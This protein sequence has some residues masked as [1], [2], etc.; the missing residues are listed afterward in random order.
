MREVKVCNKYE[1][2]K[3]L[4]LQLNNTINEMLE[5][6]MLWAWKNSLWYKSSSGLEIVFQGHQGSFWYLMFHSMN[7]VAQNPISNVNEETS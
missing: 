3:N 6:T 7:F 1:S 4:Y 2:L 5:C